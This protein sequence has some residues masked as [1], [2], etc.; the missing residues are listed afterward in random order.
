M[1]GWAIEAP[2]VCVG[3]VLSMVSVSLASSES[4]SSIVLLSSPSM[5]YSLPSVILFSLFVLL[6]GFGVSLL[7]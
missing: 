6:Y 5:L 2:L 3:V 1:V 4:V 7:R